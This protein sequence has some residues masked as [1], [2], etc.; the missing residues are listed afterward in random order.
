[1]KSIIKIWKSAGYALEGFRAAYRTDQSIRLEVLLGFPAY[2]ALGWMLAPLTPTEFMFFSGSYILIL[3]VELLNTAF[4]RLLDV[5][6]PEEHIGVKYAKDIASTAVFF[7]FV[8]AGVVVG[9][10]AWT[11]T[12]AG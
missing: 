4:E 10:L 3:I 1:M 6:H 11:R 9:T 12:F 5:V 8:F 2:L 7:S